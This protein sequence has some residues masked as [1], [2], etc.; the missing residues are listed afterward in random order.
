[1]QVI[2]R[3]DA[4]DYQSDWNASLVD[5]T[6]FSSSVRTTVGGTISVGQLDAHRDNP[7][8]DFVGPRYQLEYGADNLHLTNTGSKYLGELYAKVMKKVL[9]DGAT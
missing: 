8:S 1:M 3:R 2:W 6:Q 7:G 4:R 9:L 5:Q